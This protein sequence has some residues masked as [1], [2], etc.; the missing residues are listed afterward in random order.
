MLTSQLHNSL[1][2]SLI[3]Y[4]IGVFSVFAE[5]VLLRVPKEVIS[6]NITKAFGQRNDR[7]S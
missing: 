1:K 7:H 5:P 2:F 6:R 4:C 3:I